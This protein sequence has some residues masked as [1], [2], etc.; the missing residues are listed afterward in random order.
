M[1]TDQVVAEY[2]PVEENKSNDAS[3]P[4]KSEL[5]RDWCDKNILVINKLYPTILGET[6]LIENESEPWRH[7]DTHIFNNALDNLDETC[8]TFRTCLSKKSEVELSGIKPLELTLDKSRVCCCTNDSIRRGTIYENFSLP[9][10]PNSII[11]KNYNNKTSLK[12]CKI[13]SS[14][15]EMKTS[16]QS[17]LTEDS[18]ADRVLAVA[19][20]KTNE[21]LSTCSDVS[22]DIKAGNT[23]RSSASSGVSSSYSGSILLASIQ[24]E[25]RYEDKEEDVALLERRLLVSSV[26]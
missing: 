19:Q 10:S 3:V 25:Y 18:D 11:H 2:E 16:Q 23:R 15:S 7:T 17:L 22:E 1:T 21:W 13:H 9:G 4:R 8:N 14:N 26:V 6:F 24:E 12:K 5:I 20:N